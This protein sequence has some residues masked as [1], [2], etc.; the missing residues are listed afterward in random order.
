MARKPILPEVA[1]DRAKAT[2][3]YRQAQKAAIERIATLRAARLARE[4][5]GSAPDARVQKGA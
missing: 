5:D 1:A 3:E 4:R 2:I